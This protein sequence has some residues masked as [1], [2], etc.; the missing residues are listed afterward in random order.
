MADF[1]AQLKNNKT[2]S[3]RFY[4]I[5]DNISKN[6][7]EDNSNT[8]DDWEDKYDFDVEKDYKIYLARNF[9]DI[10]NYLKKDKR[11]PNSYIMWTLTYIKLSQ[12]K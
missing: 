8:I 11:C 12:K 9:D 5:E 3:L 10:M 2:D 6:A 1:Y 4:K 7:C